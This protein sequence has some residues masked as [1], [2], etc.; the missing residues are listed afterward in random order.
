MSST[1]IINFLKQIQVPFI[2]NKVGIYEK[3]DTNGNMELKKDVSYD[4]NN[5]KIEEIEQYQAY[6]RPDFTK[7]LKNGEFIETYL[8]YSIFLKHTKNWYCVDVDD[9]NI[10]SLSD[11]TE[12]YKEFEGCVWKQGNT[13]GIHIYVKI[14]NMP[15][16][17]NE[18]NIWNKETY[19]NIA[20]DLIR[21]KNNMWEKKTSLINGFKE[22]EEEYKIFEWDNIKKYFDENKL[23]SSSNK[24]EIIVKQNS[25]TTVFN[26]DEKDFDKNIITIKEFIKECYTFD[27]VTDYNSWLQFGIACKNSFKKDDAIELWREFS[28]KDKLKSNDTDFN[29]WYNKV[30]I[31]ESFNNKLSM[32]SF[33]Y[34]A[35][36]DNE[37]K[38][39]NIMNGNINY[40]N[41][42][43]SINHSDVCK[44]VKKYNPN[45]FVYKKYVSN[46]KV[47][48][49]LYCYDGTKWNVGDDKLRDYLSNDFYN[50]LNKIYVDSIITLNKNEIDNLT[51]DEVIEYTKK[52]K[53]KKELFNKLQQLKN[54]VFKTHCINEA[55][56]IF[57][58]KTLIFDDNKYLLGFNNCVLDLNICKARPYKYDDFV[59]YSTGWDLNYDKDG[60]II[61]DESKLNELNDL[62]KMIHPKEEER[63]FWLEILASGLDGQAYQKIFIFT[64]GGGNGK[65]TIN[66]FLI[67]ILGKDYS[68]GDVKNTLISADLVDGGNPALAGIN[69]K[70][71][72]VVK[73][74]NENKR[75]NNSTLKELTGGQETISARLLYSN[76]DTCYLNMTMC[77]EC[78][79]KPLL[80]DKA[81]DSMKRR[82]EILKFN[83]KFS[84]DDE[85]INNI[86]CF[87]KDNKYSSNEWRN[88]H[89][90][91]FLKILLDYY[92]EFKGRDY[93]F[94]NIKSSRDECRSY[95]EESDMVLNWFNQN[96][97]KVNEKDEKGSDVI[98]K[99]DDIYENFKNSSVYY[100]LSSNEK[101]KLTKVQF[102]KEF[103]DNIR[104]KERYQ[105]STYEEKDGKKIRRRKE[106]T[107]VLCGYIEV[108]YIEEEEIIEEVI[109]EDENTES[110]NDY[111]EVL[112]EDT[113]DETII[114]N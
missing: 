112:I 94:L 62:L 38:Y 28:N 64:G 100:A 15:D 20:I 46:N 74:P 88:N 21:P 8:N 60:N 73:E 12:K 97:K 75:L 30:S 67:N 18:K 40:E 44:I 101:L 66:D 58:N 24:K 14:N 32:G 33:Y 49:I 72:I 71:F 9:K 27:R 104:Y 65:G 1:K 19:G 77:I 50:L 109:E 107:N 10:N 22:N 55:T 87:K 57:E 81:G 102:F 63:N 93:N 36:C 69:R 114:K 7:K 98:I 85:D 78:N 91:E 53:L 92:K 25:K 6:E 26:I 68:K 80:K 103:K 5:L 35:K 41:L 111:D 34:W 43:N 76:D 90:Q 3:V 45:S 2:E 39:Y 52:Q 61:Y 13:K 47:Q 11:F 16:Y 106:Q 79:N 99:L 31:Q 84:D 105:T 4:K 17:I 70:R 42:I 37:I 54:S 83:T 108:E 86:N 56:T 29:E 113:D 59:T 48:W 110:T 51:D 95:I 23:F 82:L 96:Y 89:K